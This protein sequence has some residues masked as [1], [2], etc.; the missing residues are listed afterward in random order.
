[1]G[2]SDRRTDKRNRLGFAVKFVFTPGAICAV[3]VGLVL[4]ATAAGA[5]RNRDTLFGESAVGE[6]VYSQ[7]ASRL[8]AD[9]F[10]PAIS[11]SGAYVFPDLVD[12]SVRLSQAELA[13]MARVPTLDPCFNQTSQCGRG[14]IFLLLLGNSGSRTR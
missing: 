4:A 5:N 14:L 8:A 12:A 1:M 10:Q 3:T 13:G 7:V 6:S 9:L 11:D 2:A